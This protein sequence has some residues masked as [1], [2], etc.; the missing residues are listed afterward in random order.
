MNNEH[1]ILETKYACSQTFF[2]FC[3]DGNHT[4]KNGNIEIN[5]MACG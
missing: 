4:K 5:K 1:Q 3:E 2:A